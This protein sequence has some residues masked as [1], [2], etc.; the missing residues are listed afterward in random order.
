M[1]GFIIG[2]HDAWV[3]TAELEQ[4]N[5]VGK[6]RFQAYE[7]SDEGKTV[8]SHYLEMT[9]RLDP[10]TKKWELVRFKEDST[11]FKGKI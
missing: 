2:N 1:N 5:C 6:V 8:A 3:D 11:Q 7:Q 4:G 10:A 9:V